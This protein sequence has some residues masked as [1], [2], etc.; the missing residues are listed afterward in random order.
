GE[1]LGA[2]DI[3]PEV[4]RDDIA[5]C[6]A[7]LW[8][9]GYEHSVVDRAGPAAEAGRHRVAIGRVVVVFEV[10]VGG[11][12]GSDA[13]RFAALKQ[14]GGQAPVHKGSLGGYGIGPVIFVAA[15]LE[16]LPSV[17]AGLDQ[18]GQR[19]AARAHTLIIAAIGA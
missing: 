16:I 12:G 8:I 11:A 7:E 2:V 1:Q 5:G 19:V 13:A 15:L 9:V 10:G 18:A 14:L 4:R 17:G 3:G 6:G